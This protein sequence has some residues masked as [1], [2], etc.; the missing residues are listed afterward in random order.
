M[1][2]LYLITSNYLSTNERKG[3]KKLNN[4][5]TWSTSATAKKQGFDPEP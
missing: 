2:K 3:K 4:K 1:Q 5:N